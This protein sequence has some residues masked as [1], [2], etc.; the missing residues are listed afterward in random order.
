M[1]RGGNSPP[2]ESLGDKDS[3]AEGLFPPAHSESPSERKS[4]E[5]DVPF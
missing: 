5:D 2:S 4:G 1:R 3:R